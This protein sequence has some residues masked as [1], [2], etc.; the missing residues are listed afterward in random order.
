MKSFVPLC[1]L[2][3]I[4]VF[5]THAQC[6]QIWKETMNNCKLINCVCSAFERVTNAI[7]G[8]NQ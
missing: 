5:K 4:A 2:F 8:S 6:A 3:V 1:D 7:E